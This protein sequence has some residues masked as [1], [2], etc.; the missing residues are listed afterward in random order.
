MSLYFQDKNAGI[1][2][3]N[4]SFEN[5]E[6]LVSDKSFLITDPPYGINYNPKSLADRNILSG[7]PHSKTKDLIIGDDKTLDLSLLFEFPKRLIWGFPYIYDPLSTGWYVWDKQPG[8]M[9]NERLI[10]TPIEAAST[11]LW[12]GYRLVRAMW[13]GYYRDNGEKR[14]EHPT[15]KPLKVFMNPIQSCTKP[16]DLIIDFFLGSGTCAVAAK[17]LNRRFI[18]YEIEEKYC[19]MTV[20]RLKQSVMEMDL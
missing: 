7:K 5:A 1:E 3:Y 17:R 9:D 15:Q 6:W 12:S 14:W 18:G 4:E 13:A 20:E 8:I 19:E 16:G 2:I 10:T 11:T